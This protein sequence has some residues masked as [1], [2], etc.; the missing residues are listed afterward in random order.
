MIKYYKCF[1]HPNEFYFEK[2]QLKEWDRAPI[3]QHCFEV[4]LMM[5]ADW[6]RL[7]DFEPGDETEVFY[8][9]YECDPSECMYPSSEVKKWNGTGIC[10]ECL[11]EYYAGACVD[12][13]WERLEAE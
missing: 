8:R 10:K 11:S 3:C 12:F 4:R 1:Y 13:T 7:Q 5:L 9:C 2:N 6:C